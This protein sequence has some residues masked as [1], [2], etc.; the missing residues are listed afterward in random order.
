MN[1]LLRGKRE[2]KRREVLLKMCWWASWNPALPLAPSAVPRR[3]NVP[4]EAR[5][6]A[7]PTCVQISSSNPSALGRLCR[8]VRNSTI[9]SCPA[10]NKHLLCAGLAV[11]LG[12]PVCNCTAKS[13]SDFFCP[14][15]P[16]LLAAVD[17][18]GPPFWKH[19]LLFAPE[20]RLCHF[21]CRQAGCSRGSGSPSS[22]HSDS[23]AQ[24]PH[25]LLHSHTYAQGHSPRPGL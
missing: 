16:T 6:A 7:I 13:S 20:L 10:F 5:P 8:T 12:R 17:T 14:H 18:V 21:F 11:S 4:R 19:F 23:L 3:P 25:L 9:S 2:K 24:S 15:L 1:H 22:A